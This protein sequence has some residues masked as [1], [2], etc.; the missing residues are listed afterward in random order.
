VVKRTYSKFQPGSLLKLN[1][2]IDGIEPGYFVFIGESGNEFVI[3]RA[4]EDEDGDIVASDEQHTVH[5]DYAE[6]FE[7]TEINALGGDK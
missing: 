6:E 4:G 2:P 5:V 1:A 3:A 7:A